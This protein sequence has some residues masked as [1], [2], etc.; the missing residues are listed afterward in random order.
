MARDLIP[1]QVRAIGLATHVAQI[2]V[3]L[4]HV[5]E[6]T[7][8]PFGHAGAYEDAVVEQIAEA[9]AS[10][11]FIEAALGLAQTSEAA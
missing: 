11:D 9:R 6:S 4:T 3:D 7:K 10:L 2:C 8:R 5:A 1:A